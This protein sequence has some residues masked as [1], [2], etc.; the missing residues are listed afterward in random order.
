[1][2]KEDLIVGKAGERVALDYVRV[3]LPDAKI[4]DRYEPKGD[5]FIPPD[6][7]IEVKVDLRSNETGKLVVETHFRGRNSGL[8]TTKSYRWI[9]YTGTDLIITSPQLIKEVIQKG[10]Y[11]P[12]RLHFEET[13]I[14]RLGYFLNKKD[15]EETAIA[16]QPLNKE[17]LYD[18]KTKT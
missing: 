6:K 2:F 10:R 1:M 16:I 7:W 8:K 13:D 11:V 18:I 5:I 4:V 14:N 17:G 12:A 9:F 15:I 3:F